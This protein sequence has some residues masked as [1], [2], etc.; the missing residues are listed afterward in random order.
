MKVVAI[1]VAALLVTLALVAGGFALARSG[2]TDAARGA[3]TTAEVGAKS[4]PADD[5]SGSAVTRRG[6]VT[7]RATPSR[8]ACSSDE[9]RKAGDDRDANGDDD[10]DANGDDDRGDRQDAGDCDND[11]GDR[12]DV[13]DGDNDRGDRRDAGDGQDD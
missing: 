1:G 11:R 9:G 10:R 13:G 7:R 4:V 12:Q 8:S 6:Q 2:G 5:G 3:V